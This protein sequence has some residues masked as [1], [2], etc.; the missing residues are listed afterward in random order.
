MNKIE[1][2]ITA[3]LGIALALVIS[4][5]VTWALYAVIGFVALKLF[6]YTIPPATFGNVFALWSLLW[7]AQLLV[8][9][10]WDRHK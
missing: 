2:T 3:V 10:A 9:R 7:I 1:N 4:A 6:Q 5:L 8:D